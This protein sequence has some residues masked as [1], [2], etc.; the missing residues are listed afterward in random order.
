MPGRSLK[1]RT[2]AGPTLNLGSLKGHKNLPRGNHVAAEASHTRA[3]EQQQ[4]I[5]RTSDQIGYSSGERI[6]TLTS[7]SSPIHVIPVVGV[8]LTPPINFRDD[9]QS[10]IDD[11]ALRKRDFFQT[12]GTRSSGTT[13]LV[14][15]SPPTPEASPPKKIHRAQAIA[16]FSLAHRGGLESS[17]ESFETAPENQHSD[18]ES[19]SLDSP[20]LQ[21]SR[22]KWLKISGFSKHQDVG[23]GLA[24]GSDDD[25][26]T[27]Q[28]VT[29]VHSLKNLDFVAAD[30]MWD[31]RK[32]H[33][34][35]AE[36]MEDPIKP[37]SRNRQHQHQRVVSAPVVDSPTLGIG[38][39]DSLT[40]S[41]T[42]RKRVER[43]QQNARRKSI[44]DFAKRINWPLKS[45]DMDLDTEL[46]DMSDKRLSQASTASTVVEAVVINSPPRRR[47]TL[48][49]TSKMPDL[50]TPPQHSNRGSAIVEDSSVQRRLRRSES[51]DQELRKSFASGSPDSVVPNVGKKLLDTVPIIPDRRS[52]LQSTAS[53]SKHHSRT[54]SLNS[55]QQSSRPT[56]APEESVGYFD[57]PRPRDRRT[58]SVVVHAPTPLKPGS[59]VLDEVPASV[60]AEA[61]PQS[62]LTSSIGAHSKSTP[63]TSTDLD[64][65]Y[66]PVTP[67]PE[68]NVALDSSDTQNA[69]T[70]VTDQPGTSD[71]SA[72]RPRSTLV[73]PF[74]LRSAH[75]S[76]PGT[77]EVNEATAISI[78]PHTNKSI[79]VIQQTA[80]SGDSAPKERSA[81]IAGNANIAVPAL[82]TPVVHNNT[83]PKPA[84]EGMDSPLQ[85][86]REPPEPPDFK[87]IPPTP[88]NGSGSLEKRRSPTRTPIR[89]N[90]FSAPVSSLKRAISARRP[91]PESLIAPFS[92]TF[93][94]RGTAGNPGRGGQTGEEPQSRLHPLW[95]PRGYDDGSDSE[96]E[97]GNTGF[98]SGSR[99]HSY[100]S[101]SN[102]PRRTMSLTRRFKNSMRL[103]HPA[104]GQRPASMPLTTARDDYEFRRPDDLEPQQEQA[105]AVPR[106]G[107][108]VQFANFRALAE[109]I[110]KRREAK[111]EG[112]REERR[113]WLRGKI[114]P[115][116]RGSS[117]AGV[118][119]GVGS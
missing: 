67:D 21:P 51:P 90:R 2:E 99:V 92:R 61:S 105:R 75:S 97:F 3:S 23:L 114:G 47:Q 69:Q 34:N 1:T 95:R 79:L 20:S 54:F 15:Q 10:W 81:I 72:M 106:Q 119:H 45:D 26:P 112:R 29:P 33:A 85:N 62:M 88:A 115:I 46:R 14:Q 116:R 36:V 77:L 48:R 110:E 91:R 64:A 28:G 117:S 87:I 76:T 27:P 107:Y 108:P 42:L 84:P 60:T 71:W 53:G 56:T 22:Q 63:V 73:T 40:R 93:S 96:S 78:Y 8:P 4:R 113:Q 41:S 38:P 49:R 37:I 16:S 103:P 5:R 74:S 101:K 31:G 7:E 66:A 13:P 12:N 44:E 104:R 19:Q 58:M 11:A 24:L 32:K 68:P 118:V 43:L 18:D 35:P 9:F 30:H 6:K 59:K 17:T 39:D 70:L 25:E 86:P 94:L 102:P 98:L 65:F 82:V 52:S 83:L 57:I 109:R 111:E 50:N 55:R 100:D 80:G 89:A